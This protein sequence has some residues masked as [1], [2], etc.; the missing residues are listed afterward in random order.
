MYDFQES[1]NLFKKY[2]NVLLEFQRLRKRTLTVRQ[3]IICIFLVVLIACSAFSEEVNGLGF[4][5]KHNPITATISDSHTH[6]PSF[7]FFASETSEVKLFLLSVLKFYQLVISSQDKPACM[8]T[9]SCS[10]YTRQAIQKYGFIA[11]T[12]MGAARI[13][14]CNGTGRKFYSV[15]EQTG[16]LSNPVD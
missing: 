3:C 4:I 8:F 9:P 11:G 14:R 13:L 10:E 6:S 2:E 15:D 12:I 1:L 16:R 7:D 5:M